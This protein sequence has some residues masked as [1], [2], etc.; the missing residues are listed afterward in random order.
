MMRAAR[1]TVRLCVFRRATSVCW[2][3]FR[4]SASACVTTPHRPDIWRRSADA[5]DCDLRGWKQGF[6]LCVLSSALV[7][8]FPMMSTMTLKSSRCLLKS[9]ASSKKQQISG[10]AI[11]AARSVSTLTIGASCLPQ[12]AADA[13]AAAEAERRA[14]SERAA[15]DEVLI[16]L[17][18][19]VRSPR[20]EN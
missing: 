15:T 20:P 9:P 6:A 18:D 11:A 14:A 1:A 7:F 4:G 16:V 2:S 8:R 10:S 13:K 5:G 12:A 19:C 17:L 3:C